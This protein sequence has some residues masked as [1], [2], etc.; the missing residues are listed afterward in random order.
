MEVGKRDDLF[1]WSSLDFERKIGRHAVRF[2][3]SVETATK[4][5]GFGCLARVKEHCAKGKFEFIKESTSDF[6][7]S[8][9]HDMHDVCCDNK[10]GIWWAKPPRRWYGNTNFSSPT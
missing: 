5:L 3:G 7:C 1:F 6:Y 4:L 2:Q 9:V 10:K 8:K